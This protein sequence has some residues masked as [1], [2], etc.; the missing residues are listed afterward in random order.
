[1]KYTNLI[2][3]ILP[4]IIAC[5][6]AE[7]EEPPES[8]QESSEISDSSTRDWIDWETCGQKPGEHPCN[9]ALQDQNSNTIELYQYY[10]KVII[11][12]FSAMWCGVCHNIATVGD[13]FVTDYGA[14]N[15]IWLTI[16]IDNTQGDPPSLEDLQLWADLFGIE[17]PVLGGSRDMI[18]ET[19]TEGYPISS[20]PTIVVVN[21]EMML[22]NGIN[23]WNETTVR[24]W[25]ES[26]L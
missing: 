4:L 2:K 23:G 10:G 14:D 26:L 7:V 16:L 9:F 19:A 3:Y 11:I 6:P 21:K 18:D 15:V 17:L 20:W 24:A 8:T 13:D 5:K 1:M 25:V 12:D 22:Y